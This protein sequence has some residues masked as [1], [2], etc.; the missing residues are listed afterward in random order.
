MFSRSIKIVGA[1]HHN[2]KSLELEIPLGKL[3]VITGPSGSGK[4]TLASDVIFAEAQYRYLESL[5]GYVGLAGLKE[6]VEVDHIEGL[7]P[8]IALE[9]RPPSCLGRSSIAVLTGVASLAQPLFSH[10]GVLRS[11]CCGPFVRQ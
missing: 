1:R 6:A 2:L 8:A 10:Y 5:E 4:S 9:Q 7:P 11:P 3:V